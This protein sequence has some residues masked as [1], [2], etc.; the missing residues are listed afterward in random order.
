MG[1]DEEGLEV[2]V[3]VGERAFAQNLRKG[4]VAGAW[5]W[6]GRA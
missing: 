4:G 3:D 1:V 6:R 2:A 5:E